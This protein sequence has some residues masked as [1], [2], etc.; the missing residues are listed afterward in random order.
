MA[1]RNRAI[2]VDPRVFPEY[3]YNEYPKMLLKV[4]KGA[5]DGSD[6][7]VIAENK[8]HEQE[9]RDEYAAKGI[10]IPA[11]R[12]TAPITAMDFHTA[13]DQIQA[14]KAELL[15]F[16]SKDDVEA[17]APTSEHMA[18]FLASQPS[19]EARPRSGAKDGSSAQGEDPW[20]G[21]APSDD[22]ITAA[23]KTAQE[24]GGPKPAASANRLNAPG[25]KKK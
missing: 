15:K 2:P 11:F 25:T 3:E 23:M 14:L 12:S 16:K 4:P 6:L 19:S 18:E 10:E 5:P 1:G 21:E 7:L 13:Q 24:S 17:I 9:L 8:K 22:A 20:S